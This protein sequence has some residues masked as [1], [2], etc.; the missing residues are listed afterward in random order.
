M[1]TD[2]ADLTPAR[3]PHELPAVPLDRSVM[4]KNQSVILGRLVIRPGREG[5]PFVWVIVEC[6][7]CQKSHGYWWRWDWGLGP[8][9]ISFQIPRCNRGPRK[10]PAVWVA[11]DPALAAENAATHQAAH[12]A[13]LEWTAARAAR[14]AFREELT[15]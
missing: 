13:F 4:R 1:S 8:E 3:W 10:K 2:T 5:R 14:K 11:L 9:T 15:R 6:E 12:Q 7:R